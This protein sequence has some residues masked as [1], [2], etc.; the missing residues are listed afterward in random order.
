[1][2]PPPRQ[3]RKATNREKASPKKRLMGEYAVAKW[4]AKSLNFHFGQ[5]RGD[6]LRERM[7]ETR[8]YLAELNRERKA[9]GK[10]PL[11]I[12]ELIHIIRESQ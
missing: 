2:S 12:E 3:W 1:M 9:A 10:N 4:L 11:T 6:F 8:R 7:G 5:R